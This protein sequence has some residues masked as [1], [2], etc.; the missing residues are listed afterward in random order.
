MSEHDA[1]YRP[2]GATKEV[3][4]TTTELERSKRFSDDVVANLKTIHEQSGGLDAL[5]E[6]I[7]SIATSL[8]PTRELA[9]EME[10]EQLELRLA[11]IATA[12]RLIADNEVTKELK[13]S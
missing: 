13:A 3:S 2:R 5:A 10:L 6:R 4:D 1:F 7:A 8:R 9:T 12:L 11:S